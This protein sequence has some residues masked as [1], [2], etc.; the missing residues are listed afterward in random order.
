MMSAEDIYKRHA[1]MA[2][3]RNNPIGKRIN[4]DAPQFQKKRY[5]QMGS[6]EGGSRSGNF[7]KGKLDVNVLL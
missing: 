3:V 2:K 4:K 5:M 6:N 1:D 7:A